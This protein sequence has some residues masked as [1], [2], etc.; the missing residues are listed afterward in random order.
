MN[1]DERN[2]G[3]TRSM[4]WKAL[5]MRLAEEAGVAPVLSRVGITEA[6]NHLSS[7]GVP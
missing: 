6:E 2:G 5:T 4:V 3:T 7:K 1:N